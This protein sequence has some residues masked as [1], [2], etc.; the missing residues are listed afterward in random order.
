MIVEQKRPRL[1]L[2]LMKRNFKWRKMEEKKEGKN[3]HSLE[4]HYGSFSRSFYLPD[5]VSSD[6]IVAV[7]ED[8]L[9][10]INLPKAEKKV[11]KA[12]IEVK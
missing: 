3:Y 8:G 10:K 7:Y 4:T 1:G 11:N 9:L 2:F 6:S 12:K 5:D